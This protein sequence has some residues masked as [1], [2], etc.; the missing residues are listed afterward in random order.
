MSP[1]SSL[2]LTF[3]A[4][5]TAIAGVYSTPVGPVPSR[6]VAG[7]R[8][9]RRRI[10]QDEVASRRRSPRCSRTPVRSGPS[11]S[12][13]RRPQRS[14]AVRGDGRAIGPGPDAGAAAGISRRA[15]ALVLGSSAVFSPE[16]ARARSLA[17][18]RWPARADLAM[19]RSA[20]ERA[21]EKLR[22]QLPDAFELM[23]RVVRAGQTMSQALMAVA[24][25]FPQPIS[26]RVR[27]V[28][29]AAEPRPLARVGLPR[30]G[31]AHRCDGDQDLRPGP[32]GAAADRRQPRRAARQARRRS[33]AS[34]T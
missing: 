18:D 2:G 12:R 34:G 1:A 4:V 28:L 30:P 19:S 29:R 9:D 22:S 33:S 3:L 11:W 8:A 23:S 26:D 32:A 16:P 21:V 27:L 13:R 6:P 24:D 20:R 10:R 25:E 15:A 5:V 17:A 31:P 14:A 7:Q